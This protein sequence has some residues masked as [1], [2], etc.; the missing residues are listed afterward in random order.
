MRSYIKRK[1][2]ILLTTLLVLLVNHG[3]GQVLGLELLD[4][5]KQAEIKFE[6]TQGFIIVNVKFQQALPLRF[7]LDTGAEHVILFKKEIADILGLEYENKINLMGSDLGMEFYAFISRNVSLGLKN[8]PTIQRDIIVL[9]EDFLHLEELTGESIHGILGGRIFRGLVMEIDYKKSKVILYNASTFNIKDDGYTKFDLQIIKHK[10]YIKAEISLDAKET[11][12]LDLLI[13]TG[14]AL[15]F[16]V[17]L[18]SHESLQLPENFVKG[19]LGKGLGGDIEGYLSKVNLLKLAN[20]F[21]FNNVIT[22]FQHIDPNLDPI[23]YANRNGLIGNPILERFKIYIDFVGAKI[24]LKPRANYNKAFEYDKSGLIIYAFGPELS[25]FYVKD[26]IKGSPA[27][28]SGIRKG[29]MIKKI[30]IWPASFFSLKHILKKLKSKEGKKITMSL[31]RNGV[32]FKTSFRLTD[33][34][35][36][37]KLRKTEK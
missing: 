10:P 23:V 3:H 19:N 31:E 37:K 34:L 9:E 29:D 1:C 16:L 21:E 20:V 8:T 17:F 5:K 13:D 18:N 27:Y 14:A 25:N 7:I 33:F 24:Y 32:K 2:K 4:G 36:S 15:P 6:Y 26:V 28:E 11:I 35:M 22:S 30:G 12:E